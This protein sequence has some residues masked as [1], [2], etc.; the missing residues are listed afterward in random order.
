MNYGEKA[1]ELVAALAEKAGVEE[2][3]VARVLSALHLEGALAHRA[4]CVESAR[5]FGLAAHEGV[6]SLHVDNLRIAVG[7]MP[8]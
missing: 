8:C 6:E 3:A 5:R 1:N 4:A 7:A 2:R